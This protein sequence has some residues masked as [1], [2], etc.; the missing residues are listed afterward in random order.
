M[1]RE[2][3]NKEKLEYF[4]LTLLFLEKRFTGKIVNKKTCHT[5]N[6]YIYISLWLNRAF[7]D[8]LIVYNQQMHLMLIL[9]N[10]KC[11]KQ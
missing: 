2:I 5:I 7:W 1:H 9:F 6:I 10:L 4:V 11:L 8:Q 3:E